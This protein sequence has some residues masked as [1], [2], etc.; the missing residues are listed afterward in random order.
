[1]SL[2]LV[3]SPISSCTPSSPDDVFLIPVCFVIDSNYNCDSSYVAG[4][5]SVLSLIWF[6]VAP[7]VPSALMVVMALLLL[8]SV[9]LTFLE[10]S[11]SFAYICLRS[12]IDT[13]S[14]FS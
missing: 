1:M 11:F 12:P 5:F 7:F 13:V 4:P 14:I 8:I 3:N 9:C 2:A 6:D 10:D